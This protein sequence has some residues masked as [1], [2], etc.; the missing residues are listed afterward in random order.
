MCVNYMI[1]DDILAI[2]SACF[3]R[4]PLSEHPGSAGVAISGSIRLEYTEFS[5]QGFEV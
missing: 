1:R 3:E 5:T 2:S 4:P